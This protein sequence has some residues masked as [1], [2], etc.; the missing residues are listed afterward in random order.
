MYVIVYSTSEGPHTNIITSDEDMI[1]A[2]LEEL[3]KIHYGDIINYL[4]EQR[5]ISSDT[6]RDDFSHL[7]LLEVV[8]N[9]YQRKT[10]SEL[11][12]HVILAG[13]QLSE[14]QTEYVAEIISGDNLVSC[15]S[16]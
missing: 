14:R 3:M 8:T 16:N 2:C 5:K 1:K 9:M 13:T 7:Q 6:T 11:I 10:V 4:T 15:G 12:S